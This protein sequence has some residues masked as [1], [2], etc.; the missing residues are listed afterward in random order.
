MTSR[1]EIASMVAVNVDDELKRLFGNKAKQMARKSVVNILIKS[2]ISYASTIFDGADMPTAKEV[3]GVLKRDFGLRPSADDPY[4]EDAPETES[5]KDVP[6][7][8]KE[9]KSMAS[10]ARHTVKI[11]DQGDGI[12]V[13]IETRIETATGVIRS[14]VEA[15]LDALLLAEIS[16]LADKYIEG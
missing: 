15:D 6:E 16:K 12:S 10:E 4:T 3:R 7:T 5:V 1:K 9:A 11:I 2:Q 14:Y 13:A 8:Q